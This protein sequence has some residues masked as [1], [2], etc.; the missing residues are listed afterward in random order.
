VRGKGDSPECSQR[1]T[2]RDRG[3]GTT[4]QPRLWRE[5]TLQ[6]LHR[7][8]GGGVLIAEHSTAPRRC[9]GCGGHPTD[10]EPRKSPPEQTSTGRS[11]S[12]LTGADRAT[13]ARSTVAELGGDVGD[14]RRCRRIP[15]VRRKGATSRSRS[16]RG[17]RRISPELAEAGRGTRR[18]RGSPEKLGLGFDR[19]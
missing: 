9:R 18:R 13:R 19:E 5:A 10:A 17:R 7:R 1:S 16:A 15:A 14:R 8:G 6:Q 11:P 2:T 12:K 4:A 3:G